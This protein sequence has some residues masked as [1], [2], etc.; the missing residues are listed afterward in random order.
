VHLSSKNLKSP[1]SATRGSRFFEL[2]VDASD[3]FHRGDLKITVNRNGCRRVRKLIAHQGF[4]GS[5]ERPIP[6]ELCVA[7]GTQ[8]VDRT[9]F[10]GSTIETLHDG[11]DFG[12]GQNH[13]RRNPNPGH[14]TDYS[15]KGAVGFVV[16]SEIS[17]VPRKQNRNHNPQ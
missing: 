6:I 13:H 7:K 12:T 10:G 11:I 16:R 1:P 9:S 3:V 17:R 15:P 8:A 4:L 5:I 14:K 2:S